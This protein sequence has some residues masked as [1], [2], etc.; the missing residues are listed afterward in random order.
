MLLNSAPCSSGKQRRRACGQQEEQ[1]QRRSHFH[2]YQRE[3]CV[4]C[5]LTYHAIM[6]S[7]HLSP[8]LFL[9][10]WV[11]GTTPSTRRHKRSQKVK[12]CESHFSFIARARACYPRVP[13]T[14]SV[15][16]CVLSLSGLSLS[17]P[18]S[19][20]PTNTHTQFQLQCGYRVPVHKSRKTKR[21]GNPHNLPPGH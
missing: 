17:F 5:A 10:V 9:G 3:M 21:C 15:C 7:C 11:P 2:F 20:P 19:P 18:H 13:G 16:V 1:G 8:S 6:L 14:G 4:L 12:Q